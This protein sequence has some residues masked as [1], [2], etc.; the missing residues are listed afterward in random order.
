VVVV[1]GVDATGVVDVEA[2]V[3]PA[4]GGSI[5]LNTETKGTTIYVAMHVEAQR[6]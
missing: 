6:L 4:V 2:V 3:T 5:R 1:A